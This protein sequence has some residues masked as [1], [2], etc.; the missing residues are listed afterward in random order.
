[1]L[2]SIASGLEAATIMAASRIM[3]GSEPNICT[4]TGRSSSQNQ[5]SSRDLSCDF[6][7]PMMSALEETSSL[8]LIPAPYWRQRRRNGDE[9]TPAMGASTIFGSTLIPANCMCSTGSEN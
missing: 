4:A 8:Q 9:V 5:A 3:V 2:I 6:S 7:P 1:M